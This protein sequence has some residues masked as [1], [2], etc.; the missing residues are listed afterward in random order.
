LGNAIFSNSPSIIPLSILCSSTT[1]ELS[2]F[3]TLPL[4]VL[5]ADNNHILLFCQ[6][7]SLRN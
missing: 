4:A 2:P 7:I 6:E 1:P 3:N 5:P